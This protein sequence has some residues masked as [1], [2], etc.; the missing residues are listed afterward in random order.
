MVISQNIDDYEPTNIPPTIK[1]VCHNCGKDCL[2]FVCV[3]GS[4][5]FSSIIIDEVVKLKECKNIDVTC[6]IDM[7]RID[8]V[9]DYLSDLKKKYGNCLL[10]VDNDSDKTPRIYLEMR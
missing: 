1:L 4:K 6:N 3:C 8:E 2:D 9:I 7:Y 5:K 10:S